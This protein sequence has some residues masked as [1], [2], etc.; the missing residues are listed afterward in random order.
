[1]GKRSV[2]IEHVCIAHC[3]GLAVEFIIL[4][5]VQFIDFKNT[6]TAFQQKHFARSTTT[7][8]LIEHISS[9]IDSI[10]EITSYLIKI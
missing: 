8:Y 3:D 5:G 7:Y 2:F 1:M 9:Q 10:T 6:I 4:K